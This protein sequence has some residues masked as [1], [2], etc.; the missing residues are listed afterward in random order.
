MHCYQQYMCRPHKKYKDSY[1]VGFM[2]VGM[3]M[4]GIIA[5]SKSDVQ[6]CIQC[7]AVNVCLHMRTIKP[8]G[9]HFIINF[10]KSDTLAKIGSFSA[11][12]PVEIFGVRWMLIAFAAQKT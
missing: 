10:S 9:R 7:K 11:Y 5:N 12:E 6:P 1:F 3:S 2:T 8:V 4:D